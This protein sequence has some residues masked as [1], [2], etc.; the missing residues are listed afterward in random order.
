MQP[1]SSSYSGNQKFSPEES[2]MFNMRDQTSQSDEYRAFIMKADHGAFASY[3]TAAEDWFYDTE[4]AAKVMYIGKFQ[5]SDE[6]SS[7]FSGTI[8]KYRMAAE[9]PIEKYEYSSPDKVG[10]IISEVD[11]TSKWLSDLHAKQALFQKNDHP[12]LICADM[13]KQS[14][15]AC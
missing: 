2:Y 13:E 12:V 10:K 4:D 6:W 1:I 5:V 14:Q 11:S 15:A 3:L 7:A 8:S 9:S